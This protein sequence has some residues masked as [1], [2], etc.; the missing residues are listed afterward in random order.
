MPKSVAFSFGRFNPPTIGHEK[1]LDMTRGAN[2]NYRIYA[3]QSQ[4]AKSNPLSHRQKVSAM[5]KMFPTHARKIRREKFTTPFDIMVQLY[6]EKHTDVLMVVGSDRVTAFEKS[7]IPYNGKRAAHGYYKF[8]SIRIISAGQRDPDAEGVSG[9]SASKMRKAAQDKDYSSFRQG[10]PR[11]FGGG[12]Q[13]FKLVQKGMGMRTLREYMEVN[14]KKRKG[15]WANI[16][17]KRKRGE[18]PAKPGEKGYPKS[19]DIDE[20][21]RD[22]LFRAEYISATRMYQSFLKRGDKA[23][24]ALHRAATTHRH[25]TATGLRDFMS[26][27][28]K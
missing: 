7:L 22:K 28:N 2:R 21:L 19:L 27:L 8:K 5:K 10:L 12:R 24:D 13:L 17:A 11:K 9:M 25:V 18:R 26:K 1:L 15:L 16:H 4:D 20:G 23:A 6:K 14:E 3:S